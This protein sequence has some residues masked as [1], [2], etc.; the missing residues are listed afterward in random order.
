LKRP[1][2]FRRKL[3]VLHKEAAFQK[4]FRYNSKIFSSA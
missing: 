4:F 3:H 2:H 1:E